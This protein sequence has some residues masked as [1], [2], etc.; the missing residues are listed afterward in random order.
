MPKRNTKGFID[1]IS[2]IGVLMLVITLVVGTKVTNDR[3]MSLNI[4]EKASDCF[5]ECRQESGR[6]RCNE[7]C[8]VNVNWKGE[9]VDEIDTSNVPKDYE[10]KTC[11][12]NGTQHT[13][14]SKVIG[15]SGSGYSKCEGGRW[16]D[17]PECTVTSLTTVPVYK[18]EEY[19]NAVEAE[20][21]A[22]EQLATEQQTVEK[23]QCLQDGGSW[24]NNTCSYAQQKEAI[25]TFVPII[26][27]QEC[28]AQGKVLVNGECI[29]A[30]TFIDVERDETGTTRDLVTIYRDDQNN[31]V[32]S[33]VV[34]NITI[35]N[36]QTVEKDAAPNGRSS[37]TYNTIIRDGNNNII[38]YNS[39]PTYTESFKNVEKVDDGFI[40]DFTTVL[41]N[42]NTNEILNAITQSV[43]TKDLAQVAEPTTNTHN[44][45]DCNREGLTPD[46]TS[47]CNR[48]LSQVYNAP[49]IGRYLQAY[50]PEKVKTYWEIHYNSREECLADFSGKAKGYCDQVQYTKEQLASS[51]SLG[52][53]GTA[54]GAL[55]TASGG[56]ATGAITGYQ[57]IAFA[58]ATS[59]MYQTG[60]AVDICVTAPNSPECDNAKLW[61]AVSWVN[62]GS[63]GLANAYQA[64]KLAQGINTA[65]N[66]ANVGADA[67]DISQS[68]GDGQFASKFGCVAAWG[69]LVVD[70]GQGGVDIARVINNNISGLSGN[71]GSLPD[72]NSNIVPDTNR[73]FATN[74]EELALLAKANLPDV[75]K[76]NIPMA[77]IPAAKPVDTP[78]VPKKTF[79]ELFDEKITNPIINSP[80]GDFLFGKPTISLDNLDTP[81]PPAIKGN[82]P[83][84]IKP[85]ETQAVEIPYSKELDPLIE[86]KNAWN[87]YGDRLTTAYN[88]K[89]AQGLIDIAK[90]NG[91]IDYSVNGNELVVEII[92]LNEFK[93]IKPRFTA[94]VE[95]INYYVRRF[96]PAKNFGFVIISTKQGIMSNE[97]A[98]EKN[99]GGC[100]IAYMF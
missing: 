84:M 46:Q 13:E 75:P 66:I 76:A 32:G 36:T 30:Q 10:G 48:K 69:G 57:A 9:I 81:L 52:V 73:F 40:R 41:R 3:S 63:S 87:K 79:T 62:V 96:L 91:Y 49:I 47:E 22:A 89:D 7:R 37:T 100:L 93:A 20:K 80:V 35:Q 17:C 86:V 71:L 24:L 19:K 55:I 28:E 68:C 1:P 27:K 18:E 59:T 14:G 92:K 2:I 31:V 38:T 39:I 12:A 44:F 8:G 94:Q 72:V 6:E 78:S 98:K 70:V 60:S 25:A 43:N 45:A 99:I 88:N 74:A 58:M 61:A 54:V 50:S 85:V 95:K 33:S 56:A 15:G 65:V 29:S 23:S 5:N 83:D 11:D 4:S 97:D 26:E 64:S 90:E 82:A 51:V 67:L 21:K 42:Q 16:V 53:A 77:E 34:P